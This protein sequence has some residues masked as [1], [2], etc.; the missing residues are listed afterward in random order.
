MRCDLVMK[1]VESKPEE[2]NVDD[3]SELPGTDDVRNEAC[4][5][6]VIR[7]PYGA[8]LARGTCSTHVAASRKGTLRKRSERHYSM[9]ASALFHR[10]HALRRIVDAI[11]F[12]SIS[13]IS[14]ATRKRHPRSRQARLVVAVQYHQQNHLYAEHARFHHRNPSNRLSNSLG[15]PRSRCPSA[16]RAPLWKGVLPIVT[17]RRSFR[18]REP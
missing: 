8:W 12:G 16:A 10:K 1:D 15:W 6:H 7:K 11:A 5:F 14:G 2:W 4:V 13:T 18:N 9:R 17:M 3:R